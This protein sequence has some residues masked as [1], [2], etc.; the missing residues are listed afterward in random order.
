MKRYQRD[1][2]TKST[3]LCECGCGGFTNINKHEPRR[4]I[5]Q[6]HRQLSAELYIVDPETGCWVW[7]RSLT[8]TGGYAQMR[9]NGR[10][11]RAHRYFYE[12]KKGPIP[13]GLEPDHTCRNVK[14]VNPDHLE[15]VTHAENV[16]RSSMAKLDAQTRSSIRRFYVKGATQARIA[17]ML[18][19]KPRTVS[20]V[21]RGETW[22]DGAVENLSRPRSNMTRE[23]VIAVRSSGGVSIAALARQHV[24]SETTISRILSGKSWANVS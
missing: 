22:N 1:V 11:V 13:S 21:V 5:N 18:G 7:Q 20:A 16:R 8:K 19:L 3:H 15:A 2:F 9:V 14:C 17:R 24:V 4:F 12:Q 10:M 6:H 23:K